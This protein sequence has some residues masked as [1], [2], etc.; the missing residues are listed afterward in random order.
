MVDKVTYKLN[1]KNL[2]AKELDLDLKEEVGNYL[3]E[4]ILENCSEA[5][6]SVAGGEWEKKLSTK[7]KKLKSEVSG[8]NKANMELYGDMLDALEFIPTPNGIEVGIFDYDQAQKAD[9]HNK[10]S[11]ASKRTPLPPRQFIP[12]RGESFDLN[13]LAEIE[14]IIAEHGEE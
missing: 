11:A 6:T 1:L 9:N 12:R 7:Y 2:G 10:F 8:S 3:V 13:I 14:E 5:K 4:K